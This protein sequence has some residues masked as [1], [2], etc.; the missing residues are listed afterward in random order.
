MTTPANEPKTPFLDKYF[1]DVYKQLVGAGAKLRDLYPEVDLSNALVELVCV[2]VSQLNRC[3]YCLSIHTPR[4]RKAGVAEVK[5]DL[6]V[7]WREAEELY[8][9]Q[10]RAALA[11][12]EQLTLLPEGQR[13]GDAA[14]QA[15][16]VFAEEQ[17]AALEWVVVTMNAF[18]RVSIASGHP[19][20]QY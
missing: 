4:A 18:N 3:A 7:A 13:N 17:V 14:L 8:T 15:C 12:A 16:E 5:L 9:E 6:L 10:E 20:R 11:L 19:P 2:R 1:P